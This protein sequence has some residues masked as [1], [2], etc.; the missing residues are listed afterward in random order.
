MALVGVKEAEVTGKESQETG[1][2]N[3]DGN[4]ENRNGGEGL[5]NFPCSGAECG[6]HVFLSPPSIKQFWCDAHLASPLFLSGLFMLL[7][8]LSQK[9]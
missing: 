3:G 1:T 6:V 2:A 4:V 7:G 8:A 9:Q 5:H